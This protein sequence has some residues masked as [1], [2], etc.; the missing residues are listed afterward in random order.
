V[1]VVYPEG[2]PILGNTKVVAT[3]AVADTAAPSLATEIGAASA[4]DLSC[5]LLPDGWN[6]TATQGKGTRPGRLCSKSS[7]E[8]LNRV[9]YAGPTLKY[10]WNPQAADAGAGNEAKELLVE[11]AE[12][13]FIERMGLDAQDDPFT[14]AEFVVTHKL[15]LGAQIKSGD[16]TDENGDFFIMQETEYVDEGPVDGIVAA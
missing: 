11:D 10:I 9:T 12:L 13:F 2:T 14:A 16:R 7:Q 15:R 8:R 1:T 6:P 3:A 4:V 5:Y